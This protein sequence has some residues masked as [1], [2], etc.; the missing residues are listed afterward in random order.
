MA[1][2]YCYMCN[3]D[4]AA[5]RRY[6]GDGL[7]KGEVCPICYQPTCRHHLGTVRWRWRRSGE[8]DAALVCKGCLRSYKHR[9]WDKLNREWI[10]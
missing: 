1:V 7:A 4:E 9:A 2:K 10:T 3:E 6:G 8:V 5:K